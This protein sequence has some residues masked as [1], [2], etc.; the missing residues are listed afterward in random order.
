MNLIIAFVS[1]HWQFDNFVAM[2]QGEMRKSSRAF[3]CFFTHFNTLNGRSPSSADDKKG[4]QR[5]IGN[6]PFGNIASS[7]GLPI[8]A[9]TKN[10]NI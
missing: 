10:D 7:V 8:F 4:K 1:I 9:T 5:V 6:V 2:S 3:L